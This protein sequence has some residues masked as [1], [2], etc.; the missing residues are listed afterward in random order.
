MSNSH[1]VWV[2][3][4]TEI[5][6]YFRNQETDDVLMT[7]PTPTAQ[8]LYRTVGTAKVFTEQSEALE[9]KISLVEDQLAASQALLDESR[10]QLLEVRAKSAGL[11]AKPTCMAE[12][13]PQA[14]QGD[15][16]I[17]VDP[18]MSEF[19]VTDQIEAMG[20]EK[21]LALEDC[22]YSSDDLRAGRNVEAWIRDWDGPFY[23]RVEDAVRGYFEEKDAALK[24][25][26]EGLAKVLRKRPVRDDS[27]EP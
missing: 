15:Y 12:F 3:T 8:T 14:W 17:D 22:E 5:E 13:H 19:D 24:K 20:R 26:D 11:T 4:G 27:P 23:V 1:K 21:A 16:A 2:L 25:A 10:Q 6:P 18:G 7:T 9:A